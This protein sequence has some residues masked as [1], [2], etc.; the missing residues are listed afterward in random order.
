MRT[1]MRSMYMSQLRWALTSAPGWWPQSSML[2]ALS[3]PPP[4]AGYPQG[5]RGFMLAHTLSPSAGLVPSSQV[6]A[7]VC[8]H[9]LCKTNGHSSLTAPRIPQYRLTL[10]VTQ[11]HL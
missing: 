10:G 9:C 5:P 4:P 1:H 2:Q 7:G 3:S 8:T 6:W 11:T